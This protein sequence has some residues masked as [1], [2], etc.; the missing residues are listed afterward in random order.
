MQTGVA[1]ENAN[2]EPGRS[3][4]VGDFYDSETGHW[5]PGSDHRGF[6][7]REKLHLVDCHFTP[8]REFTFLTRVQYGKERSFQLCWIAVNPWVVYSRIC[9]G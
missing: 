4:D 8:T 1:G 6:S 2:G 7:A 3:I 9:D 5:N